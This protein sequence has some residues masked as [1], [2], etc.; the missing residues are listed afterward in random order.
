ML[1]G[2]NGERIRRVVRITRLRLIATLIIA[3]DHYSVFR[4][5][6]KFRQSS[7][8]T[9]IIVQFCSFLKNALNI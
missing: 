1:C 9:R 7:I 4:T 8:S 3:D 6:I 2:V 5:S